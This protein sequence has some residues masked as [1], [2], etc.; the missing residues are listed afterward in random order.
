MKIKYFM[1]KL[2]KS[3]KSN[4]R[5]SIE[6]N[7]AYRRDIS[8]EKEN[9]VWHSGSCSV[10]LHPMKRRVL[11]LVFVVGFIDALAQSSI[12]TELGNDANT[13]NANGGIYSITTDTVGNVY[14]TGDFTNDSDKFYVA[15]W[16]GVIWKEL[17]NNNKGLNENYSIADICT[18][19]F[20][21]YAVSSQCGKDDHVAEFSSGD[22]DTLP[23]LAYVN[24]KNLMIYSMCTDKSGNLYAG[25]ALCD[26]TNKSCIVKWDAGSSIWIKIPISIQNYTLNGSVFSI[27]ADGS[28][29][30]YAAGSACDTSGYNVIRFD[31]TT[32]NWLGSGSNALNANGYISS[33]CTDARGHVYAA[34][35]FTNEY[36][37]GYVSE[38][39]G[40][41]WS[42]LGGSNSLKA[43]YYIESI[44]TDGFGNVY[45]AGY[46]TNASGNR[47]V[48]CWD[49]KSWNEL[50]GNN[51][52]KANSGIY[53]ICA[54]RQENIY[55]AGWFT[56]SSGFRYVAK[57][58]VL[59]GVHNLMNANEFSFS[60]NPAKDRVVI[61]VKNGLTI[62]DVAIFDHTGQM[63]LSDKASKNSID[64]SNL[65]QGMYIVEVQ[66]RQG[67]SRKKLVID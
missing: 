16:D 19:G 44:C 52:L 9:I 45:A 38:W 5:N 12:W 67:K 7:S 58:H 40:T 30:V 34:G 48:A 65:H 47:Y 1:S 43:N 37:N 27:C 23:S 24:M 26:S 13:L 20:N 18:D 64:V 8:S 50:G 42:E 39:D 60:P 62:E 53:S 28:G 6:R 10:H 11:F 35:D 66:T 57:Y 25:G 3:C 41:H 54:D 14:A 46:F 17:I 21:I 51:T 15:R 63:V 29:N 49:G 2:C 32:W 36:G 56:N 22:W 61:S 59:N 33:I 31:G 4:L 55:A